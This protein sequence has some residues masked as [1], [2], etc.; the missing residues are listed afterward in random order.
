MEKL[1]E[2]YDD[3]INEDRYTNMLEDQRDWKKYIKSDLRIS[4][5]DLIIEDDGSVVFKLKKGP[6]LYASG[7]EQLFKREKG[8][9]SDASIHY[10]GD[11]VTIKLIK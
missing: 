10:F 2:S 4:V 7:F 11:E 8:R 9:F 1:I 6:V 3:F 5:D